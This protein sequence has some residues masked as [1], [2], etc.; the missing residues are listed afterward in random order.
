MKRK[1]TMF[2]TLFFV[3]LGVITAQTQVR[4]TVVDES[5]DPVIGATIQVKGTSQG[6]VSDIDG[7]FTLSAPAGGTL[8]VS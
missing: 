3:G 5:G 6:T 8:I 7:N 1:L 2:L 4:G